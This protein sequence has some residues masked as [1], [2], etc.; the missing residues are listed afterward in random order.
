MADRPIRAELAASPQ[1]ADANGTWCASLVR[2]V[3]TFAAPAADAVTSPT[4]LPVAS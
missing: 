3:V 4:P 2:A 1:E